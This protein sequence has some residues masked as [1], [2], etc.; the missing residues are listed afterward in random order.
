[1]N[2]EVFFK[3][4]DSTKCNSSVI[5]MKA[6]QEPIIKN[7]QEPIISNDPLISKPINHQHIQLI[8][9]RK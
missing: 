2:V 5:I 6:N 1:M 8:I 9:I 3:D 4:G 7:D